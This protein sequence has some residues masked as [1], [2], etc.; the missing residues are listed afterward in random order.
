MLRPLQKDIAAAREYSRADS[1]PL[2]DAVNQQFGGVP[3]LFRLV[4]IR[5]P[6]RSRA[7]WV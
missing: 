4:G 5:A 3:N 1:R 7:F 6:P 2:L